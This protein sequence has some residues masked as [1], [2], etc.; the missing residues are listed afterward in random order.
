M[1]ALLELVNRRLTP[2]S[3]R[4]YAKAAPSLLAFDGRPLARRLAAPTLVVLGRLDRVAN[5]STCIE[6]A[7]ALPAGELM[8]V[9]DVAHFPHIE[10]PGA[11]EPAIVAHLAGA[12]R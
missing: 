8:L 3:T 7:R 1:A 5:V 2:V 11:V 12:A 10:A 4:T 9:D 6:L